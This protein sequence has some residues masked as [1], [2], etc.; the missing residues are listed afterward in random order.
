MVKKNNK[1]LGI[2]EYCEGKEIWS[3]LKDILD[4][5]NDAVSRGIKKMV[6]SREIK[7]SKKAKEI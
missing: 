1:T 3:H 7:I 4:N 6:F 2:C 5:M